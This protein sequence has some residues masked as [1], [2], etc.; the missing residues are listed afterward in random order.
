MTT[1]FIVSPIGADKSATRSHAD[2]VMNFLISPVCEELSITPV[3]AD[4]IT[5]PS[6]I[7]DDV[8]EHLRNDTLVIADLTENNFNVLIE[9][10][11]R[12]RDG[13]PMILIVDKNQGLGLPFDIQGY[14]VLPYCLDLDQIELSKANLKDY[15][16]T[17]LKKSATYYKGLT[18]QV[19]SGKIQ[20][21]RDNNGNIIPKDSVPP[22]F[23]RYIED[24]VRKAMHPSITYW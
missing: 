4:K 18:A 3:R 8:F 17:A 7:D 19:S 15:I 12:L 16:Q 22:E 13:K 14:R 10:G 2:I 1:C 23:Q 6:R 11:Y 5:G 9:I 21:L 20:T 24:R